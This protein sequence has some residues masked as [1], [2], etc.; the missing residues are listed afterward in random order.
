MVRSK[1]CFK[2]VLILRFNPVT[3]SALFDDRSLFITH[4]HNLMQEFV[5]KQMLVLDLAG[6]FVDIENQLTTGFT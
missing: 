3:L 2:S 1:T 4:S 5:V 6:Q